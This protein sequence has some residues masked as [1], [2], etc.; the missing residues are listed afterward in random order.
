MS[1]IKKIIVLKNF[2]FLNK[3][4]NR[5]FAEIS[6]IEENEKNIDTKLSF[7]II[8]KDIY[9]KYPKKYTQ[10][11]DFKINTNINI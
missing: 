9:L 4:T 5:Y 7:F 3:Y 8:S 6:G 10:D 11:A 1:K 2:Y